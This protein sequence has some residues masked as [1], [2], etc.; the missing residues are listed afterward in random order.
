MKTYE[1][2]VELQVKEIKLEELKN[3]A[4]IWSEYDT[5]N[6]DI[7]NEIEEMEAEILTLKK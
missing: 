4:E 3:R 1:E 2:H 5:D 7:F 6:S